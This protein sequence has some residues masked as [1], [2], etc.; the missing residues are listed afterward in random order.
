[1]DLVLFDESESTQTRFVG[2]VTEGNRYDFTVTYSQHF[3]GKA[4]VTCLQSHR[5]AL[6]DGHDAHNVEYLSS[7]FNLSSEEAV[8]LS[9]FLQTMLDDQL[10]H[11]QY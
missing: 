5:S 8:H 11:D 4:I 2:F 3:W 7:K 1:M 10:H 6:L 9:A